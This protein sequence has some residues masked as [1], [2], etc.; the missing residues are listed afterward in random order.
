VFAVTAFAVDFMRFVQTRMATVDVFLTFFILAAFYLM[1][2]YC[3]TS[4]KSPLRKLLIPLA[5]SGLFMGLAISVKW[6]G[7]YAG[8]GLAIVFFA[9]LW[10]RRKCSEFKSR[11]LPLLGFCVVF[12]VIVPIAVYLHSYIPYLHAPGMDGLKSIW[13]NQ[14]SMF[15]YHSELTDRHPFESPWWQ[16]PL[17]IRPVFLYLASAAGGLHSVISVMG[18]PVV[19]LA[20]LIAIIYLVCNRPDRT[21]AFLFTAIAAQMVPWMPIDRCTFIYHY[22]PIVGFVILL[23]ARTLSRFNKREVAAVISVAAIGLFIVYYPVLT[24]LP[25]DPDFVR[26]YLQWL[27]TW[28]II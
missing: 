4:F 27:P 12:F 8:A 16:W 3:T 19:W 13:D 21:D 26:K 17:N 6:S 28:I 15:R 20:G 10:Q 2:C 18:N 9:N 11:V 23:L 24:G 7:V 5:L 22:F 25:A 1:H 14:L